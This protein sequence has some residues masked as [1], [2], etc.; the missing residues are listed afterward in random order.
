MTYYPP[1]HSYQSQ[2]CYSLTSS[3]S[4]KRLPSTS[5]HPSAAPCLTKP[6]LLLKLHCTI[7]VFHMQNEGRNTKYHKS[8]FKH[9]ICGCEKLRSDRLNVH[10]QSKE[11]LRAKIRQLFQNQLN[12]D[13]SLKYVDLIIAGSQNGN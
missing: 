12:L 8:L 7:N 6:V 4:P 1:S 13:F 10:E 2:H 3:I 9:D 11:M 5:Y